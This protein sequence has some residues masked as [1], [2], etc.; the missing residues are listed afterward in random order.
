MDN[1]VD[2]LLKNNQRFADFFIQ[3]RVAGV[4]RAKIFNQF[5]A[6]FMQPLNIFLFAGSVENFFQLGGYEVAHHFN[7]SFVMVGYR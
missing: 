6:G 5:I 2:F 4:L 7:E 1:P 3:F